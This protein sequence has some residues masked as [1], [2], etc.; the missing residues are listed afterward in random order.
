MTIAIVWFKRDL[1]VTDHRALVAA[2]QSNLP[3]L[4][5]FILEPD[6]MQQLDS[7]A[8]QYAFVLEALAD[9]RDQLSA[10]GLKLHT[11]V[12]RAEIVFED[13]RTRFGSFTLYS[14]EETGNMWTYQRDMRVQRWCAGHNVSWH[15]FRQNGVIR[16]M[17]TRDGWAKKWDAFMGEP[18]CTLDHSI[19]SAPVVDISPLPKLGDLPVRGKDCAGRQSGN[20]KAA[21]DLLESFL[22]ARGRQYRRDMASPVTAENG[23]SRLSPY[24][25]WGLLSTR[26]VA[27]RTWSRLRTLKQEPLA[28]RRGWQG[29]LSAFA[30]RLHWRCHFMQKL[31][32]QP[33]IEFKTLHPLYET[34]RPRPA[35]AKTL[36]AWQQGETGYPFLDAAIRYLDHTG[37][38]N[39]RMRAMIMAVASYHLWLDWRETGPHLA[40]QFVDYE[41]G[42]HWPQVQMQSGTTGMNTV[43]IYNP[44][45]QGYDQDPEGH[46]IRRWIPELKAV[47]DAFVHEPWKWPDL[48]IT[49]YPPRIFDHEQSAREAREKV[50]AVRRG[51]SFRSTRD[52]LLVKHA[53]R[54]GRDKLEGPKKRRKPGGDPNQ[55]LN[56]F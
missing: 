17:K 42:I 16:R 12:A 1:R 15:E 39:F 43:R 35:E 47:P 3:V 50:W 30:G 28:K 2:A 11:P 34:L 49:D 7:S 45:K 6:L 44:V 53:S 32:D 24:L 46:F 38:I 31:E 27:Q 41:P 14:H 48:H 5:L 4:P 13:L 8:R 23:C 22:H 20:R 52:K 26:E 40:R 29:S 51:D 56:L 18:L 33:D 54:R 25:V 9:L 21:D 55:Q 37:W 10:F 36:K 19:P